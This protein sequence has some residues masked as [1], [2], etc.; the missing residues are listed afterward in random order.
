MGSHLRHCSLIINLKELLSRRDFLVRKKQSC[1]ISIK[2]K[3]H[4][5]DTELFSLLESQNQDLLNLFQQQITTIEEKINELIHEDLSIK[6]NYQ[7]LQ[8]ITGIGPIISAYLIAFTDNFSLFTDSRKFASYAGIA[9]FPNRSGI[10]IGRSR[11]SPMANKRIKSL[12][13]NG[14]IS[15]IVFDKELKIYYKRKLKEGKQ[16]GTALNAVKNK[17][18]HRVF[19]VI[20]RQTPYVKIMQYA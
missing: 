3:K 14:A 4:T 16:K 18:I 10:R 15:A 9:P 2:E 11:V 7:L 6:F 8:S 12:L 19:A 20:K 5:L 1:E 13:S 17:L